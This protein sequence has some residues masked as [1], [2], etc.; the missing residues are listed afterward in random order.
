MNMDNATRHCIDTADAIMAHAAKALDMTRDAIIGDQNLHPDFREAI[1]MNWPVETR[2][3]DPV[4]AAIE[5]DEADEQAAKEEA[6][7]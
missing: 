6:G 2:R 1:S 5:F 7:E 4:E 3:F